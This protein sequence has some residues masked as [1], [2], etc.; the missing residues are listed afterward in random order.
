MGHLRAIW[1]EKEEEWAMFFIYEHIIVSTSLSLKLPNSM[2]SQ[3]I[4][5]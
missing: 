2:G 4:V 1:V 3:F 5:K